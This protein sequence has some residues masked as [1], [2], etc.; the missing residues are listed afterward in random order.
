MR[1]TVAAFA[2][3]TL[4]TVALLTPTD[5]TAS[6]DADVTPSFAELI[7]PGVDAPP[8]EWIEPPPLGARHAIL[9]ETR[10]G[11]VLATID[12]DARVPVASTIK[13]LTALTVGAR[14][15]TDELVTAGDEVDGLPFDGAS[16][17]LEP[18]DTWTVEQL[19]AGII[20]RSGNDAASALAVHVAGGAEGFLEL[21]REDAAALGLEGVTIETVHG[22]GDLDRLSARD[23][24]TIGRAALA[25]EQLA[26]VLAA[27]SVQL[28]GLGRISSRNELLVTYPGADGVKTGY[29]AAA[30][31]TL[32]ASATRD[33]RQL[34]A[35]VLGSP[36]LDG[37]F[38][39]AAALLDHGFERFNPLPTAGDGPIAELRRPG[40][41]IGLD[42]A[43]AADVLVP[44]GLSLTPR[45]LLVPPVEADVD[46]DL[47]VTMRWGDED[48]A[49]L[50]LTVEDPVGGA[51]SVEGAW[52]VDRAYAAMRA[53]TAADAWPEVDG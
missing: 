20:A 28:P 9:V 1:R 12:A 7:D 5:A 25:D 16:V 46:E 3:L 30:G 13:A 51:P 22:L 14:T 52:I 17:G 48:L 43:G 8:A 53:V 4:A 11:Q 29:T 40:R 50:P 27:P 2:C 39:D 6:A 45:V 18:G 21:M 42:S 15:E 34:L 37:H 31:R 24:A 36:G 35:V 44:S 10:T 38:R 49:H 32:I 47:V 41:W 19:T 26:A 33:G 23:L